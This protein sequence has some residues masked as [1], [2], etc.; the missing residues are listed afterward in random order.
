MSRNLR[1]SGDLYNAIRNI[2]IQF[3]EKHGV[4]ISDGE[5]SKIYHNINK[6]RTVQVKTKN[7][8][9]IEVKYG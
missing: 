4:N 2:R 7:K 1:V 6:G 3:K 8:G 5:A 9:I